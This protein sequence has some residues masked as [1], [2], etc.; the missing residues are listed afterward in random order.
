MPP[1]AQRRRAGLEIAAEARAPSVAL[2]L[3]GC[4]V[5]RRRGVVGGAGGVMNSWSRTVHPTRFCDGHSFAIEK[6]PF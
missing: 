6:K 3:V 5:S 4:V 2:L 1:P